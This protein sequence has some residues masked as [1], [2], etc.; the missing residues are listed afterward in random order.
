MHHHFYIWTRKTKEDNAVPLMINIQPLIKKNQK[1]T[2]IWWWFFVPLENICDEVTMIV[3]I[4]DCIN[5]LSNNTYGNWNKSHHCYFT[6]ETHLNPHRSRK[7]KFHLWGENFSLLSSLAPEPASCLVYP[8]H[9]WITLYWSSTRYAS[10][11]QGLAAGQM[12][13]SSS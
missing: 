11:P 2:F 4:I 13:P 10:E 6:M 5:G 1:K 8:T 12:S 9:T 3:I 7:S